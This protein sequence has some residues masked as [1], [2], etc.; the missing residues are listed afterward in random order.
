[1]RPV[2]RQVV[3]VREDQIRAAGGG[4][5]PGERIRF[6]QIVRVERHHE[7]A[8]RPGQAQAH[9]ALDAGVLLAG[10]HLHPRIARDVREHRA[11]VGGYRSVLEHDPLEIAV[12]LREERLGGSR[13]EGGRRSVVDARQ[14]R[15]RHR[16][17]LDRGDGD[18]RHAI[19]LE[20]LFVIE[21]RQRLSGRLAAA[22][23][24]RLEVRRSQRDVAREVAGVRH[25]VAVG[26]PEGGVLHVADVAGEIALRLRREHRGVDHASPDPAEGRAQPGPQMRQRNPGPRQTPQRS[27]R[28]L[29]VEDGVIQRH[30]AHRVRLE[31]LGE[32]SRIDERPLAIRRVAAEAEAEIA[33]RLEEPAVTMQPAADHRG[34]GEQLEETGR[35]RQPVFVVDPGTGPDHVDEATL[36]DGALAQRREPGDTGVRIERDDALAHLRQPRR[37]RRCR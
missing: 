2:V 25:Q 30:R 27:Q 10:E 15:E 33:T 37:R 8:L 21:E 35:L 23:C 9:R 29:R 36:G 12:R 28:R 5:Q 34:V 17:G 4:R 11:D 32:V 13:E 3:F 22:A 1:M 14:H 31:H 24:R 6:E 16:R 19:G 26:A 7:V 18:A 20:L